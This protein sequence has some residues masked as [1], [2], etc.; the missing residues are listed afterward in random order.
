MRR[1]VRLASRVLQISGIVAVI[2]L[3]PRTRREG[4]GG[5]KVKHIRR[6]RFLGLGGKCEV[7]MWIPAERYIDIAAERT[8]G[9]VQYFRETVDTLS[10]QKA[11]AYLDMLVRS[12]YMQGVTDAAD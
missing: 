7:K 1:R 8:D 11:W 2:G 6:N 4:Q 12:A 5:V 3:F 10:W 9:M